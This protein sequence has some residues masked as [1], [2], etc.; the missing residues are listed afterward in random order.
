MATFDVFG[1]G[2]ALVDIQAQ[3]EDPLLETLSIEKGVMTLV[4]NDQQAGVLA[5]LDGRS[6]NRCAGG[7]AANTI[8]A[9]AEM[10]GKAGYF[11]KVGRDDVG[12][13][14]L[15]EMRELGVAMEVQPG[16]DPTGTCAVLITDD[17]QRT[18]LTNLGAS[19]T[20]TEDD[21]DETA[22]AQ[23]K[24]VYVE[25]YL[26]T[27]DTT[28]AA[29]YKAMALAKKN[30]AKIAFTA[31]DPFLVNLIRDEIWELITGPVDLF[32]CN[33]E[34]A[35]SLTN[36]DDPLIAAGKIHEHCENVALTLGGKGSIVVHGGESFPIEG[37]TVDALDTTGAGDMY[38][39]AL[40]YGI[41]NGLEWPAAGHLASHAAAR[42]V[43]QLGARLE[44][45]FT[46]EEIAE[47][48]RTP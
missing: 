7:S 21:I 15:N 16:E 24:Y 4:D 12:E 38:A 19:A 2:N 48:G 22:I 37:V 35:K 5:S 9:I 6:L 28:K 20:L 11:G 32:F 46:S 41:T 31:S 47:L 10:G 34:E 8:V 29:A 45:K 39:G 26:L 33:E 43:A 14:F 13:F 40:L 27:G 1:V 44:R 36:E 25:G 42:I 30:G 17:A 18:M 3:V 23:S